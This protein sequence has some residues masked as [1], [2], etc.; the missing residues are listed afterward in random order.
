MFLIQ[1]GSVSV[2]IDCSIVKSLG[3]REYFGH[4]TVCFA[5]PRSESIRVITTEA[6]VFSLPG[7]VIIKAVKARMEH[8]REDISALFTRIH[9]FN[10]LN[11]KERKFLIENTQLFRLNI[12]EPLFEK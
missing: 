6:R 12:G 7:S 10:Y 11:N 8:Y 5:S 3:E 4:E 9:F 1:A 2:E